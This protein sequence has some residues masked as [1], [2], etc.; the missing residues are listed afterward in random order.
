MRRKAMFAVLSRRFKEGEV[1]IVEKISIAEPKTKLLAN[2]LEAIA[3]K[4]NALIITSGEENNLFKAASN[5]PK[6]SVIDA[7]SLNVYDLLR[8]TVVLIE[9]SALDVINEHYHGN[10]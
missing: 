4:Q 5:L 6:I 2:A 1:K 9:Q 3:P 7:R 10:E 8:H